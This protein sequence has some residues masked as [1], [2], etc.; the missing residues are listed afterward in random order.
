M[1]AKAILDNSIV[2]AGFTLTLLA[3]SSLLWTYI[4]KSKRAL[5]LSFSCLLIPFALSMVTASFACLGLRQ[6]L[7]LF[8]A[9]IAWEVIGILGL[10]VSIWI[11]AL[12]SLSKKEGF[13]RQESAKRRSKSG[14]K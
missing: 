2:L 13:N 5:V 3:A 10:T 8:L 11:G 6:Y 14:P 7:I 12:D 4:K 1:E 9:T